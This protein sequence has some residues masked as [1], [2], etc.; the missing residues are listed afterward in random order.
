MADKAKKQTQLSVSV[1]ERIL[2]KEKTDELISNYNKNRQTIGQR[3]RFDTLNLPVTDAEKQMVKDFFD[4][5]ISTKQMTE[6]YATKDMGMLTMRVNVVCKRMV[7]Q[8]KE[9]FL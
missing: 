4:T 9:K 5:T 6:K 8:N 3:T 1:L 7:S 2:G